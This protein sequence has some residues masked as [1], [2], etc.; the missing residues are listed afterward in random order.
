M[1]PRREGLRGQWTSGRRSST[2]HLVVQEGGYRVRSLGSNA[3]S[4]FT[5]LWE[6]AFGIGGRSPSGKKELGLSAKK[7]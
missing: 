6:T 3:R 7:T 5:G 1:G 4:F 2:A